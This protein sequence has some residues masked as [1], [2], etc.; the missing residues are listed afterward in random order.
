MDAPM[1][2]KW[3]LSGEAWAALT[4]SRPLDADDVETLCDNFKVAKRALDK[5][6][7][8]EEPSS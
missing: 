4:V 5:A 7:R 6:A 1:V 8:T 3:P 2:F